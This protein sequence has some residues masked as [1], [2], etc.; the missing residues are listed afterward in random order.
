LS[1][2]SATYFAKV[3]AVPKMVSSWRGKLEVSRQRNSGWLCATA[4]AATPVAAP[5]SAAVLRRFR[6]VWR[7]VVMGLVPP[8][9]GV[10]SAL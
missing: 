8:V 5:A 2:A 6:L 9:C 3:C 10:V 1:V 7:G 4:G